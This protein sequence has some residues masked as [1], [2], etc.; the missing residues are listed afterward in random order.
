MIGS[1]YA[2]SFQSLLN[3]E[4]PAPLGYNPN[5]HLKFADLQRHGY[6]I[7]NLTKEKAEAQFYFSSDLLKRNKKEIAGEKWFTQAGK[8]KLQSG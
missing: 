7:L 1:F 5:P 3:K 2:N 8:N 4:L 6:F